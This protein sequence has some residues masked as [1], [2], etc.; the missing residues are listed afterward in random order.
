MQRVWHVAGMTCGHCKK[1]VEG[2]A[3]GVAGV[4]A[5]AVDLAA[6]TLTVEVAAEAA[7]EEIRAAI[8][9]EGYEIVP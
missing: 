8:E 9:E 7:L 2:A 1:A 3:L 4:T 6:K 5:A